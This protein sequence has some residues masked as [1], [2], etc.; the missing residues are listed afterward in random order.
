MQI[1]NNLV[2]ANNG[3]S[4]V[5]A[6][7][8][9]T[10]TVRANPS[11]TY[12][13]SLNGGVNIQLSGFQVGRYSGYQTIQ[14]QV[15]NGEGELKMMVHDQV[16]EFIAFLNFDDHYYFMRGQTDGTAFAFD[17]KQ[18]YENIEACTTPDV[19]DPNNEGGENQNNAL[20]DAQ[21]NTCQAT[22][23]ILMVWHTDVCDVWALGNTLPLDWCQTYSMSLYARTLEHHYYHKSF[24]ESLVPN[25]QVEIS[26]YLYDGVPA[27]TNPDYLVRA[28]E[29]LENLRNDVNVQAK[30][31]IENADIVMYYSLNSFG[32]VLGQAMSLEMRNET[33]YIVLTSDAVTDG[34]IAL[35][36]TGHIWGARH[37]KTADPLGTCNHAFANGLTGPIQ[38]LLDS[39]CK[40]VMWSSYDPSN[41]WTGF[42]NPNV[43]KGR[44]PRGSFT[45]EYNASQISHGTCVTAGFSEDIP[46]DYS[47]V[48]LSF[49]ANCG[50]RVEGESV[51]ITANVKGVFS[52][53]LPPY[54][55]AFST[56]INQNIPAEP[57]PPPSGFSSSNFIDLTW[58]AN[59]IDED[60]HVRVWVKSSDIDPVTQ[61]DIVIINVEDICEAPNIF[62][63]S[64]SIL[65]EDFE[66][67]LFPNPVVD[68]GI[69]SIHFNKEIFSFTVIDR[70]GKVV[71]SQKLSE[72]RNRIDLNTGLPIYAEGLYMIRIRTE[73][74]TIVKKFIVQ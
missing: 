28:T 25:K 74:K 14:A 62:R 55:Y 52:I 72:D 38:C 24:F 36:E 50:D 67:S 34:N 22:I 32:P 41:T 3:I 30:R 16:D 53:F 19:F 63:S 71:E 57:A 56:A 20:C 46:D 2:Q 61:E 49:D 51:R 70:L 54:T 65:V 66:L 48:Y 8:T 58:D 31:Q 6:L 1:I 7:Q 23:D 45:D 35:H 33:P 44:Q 37:E 5:Y 60:L 29:E 39:G 12:W 40:T 69:T 17:F 4:W 64:S 9:N 26:T 59:N 47:A 27:S 10:S 43:L 15:Q 11:G 73:N 13:V 42:S 21:I 68:G 18:A